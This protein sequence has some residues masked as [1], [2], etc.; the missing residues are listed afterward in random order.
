MNLQSRQIVIMNLFLG[1]KVHDCMQ[2]PWLKLQSK[3][4]LENEKGAMYIFIVYNRNKKEFFKCFVKAHEESN[5]CYS[6]MF[7]PVFKTKVA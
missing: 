3:T 4:L 7:S 6:V 1:N 2:H 5:R